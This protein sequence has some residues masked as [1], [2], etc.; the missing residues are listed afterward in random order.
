MTAQT[1]NIHELFL[2]AAVS[3]LP[4]VFVFLFLQRYLVRA[5]RRPASRADR[6]APRQPY[7]TPLFAPIHPGV[8][9]AQ[10]RQPPAAR[11]GHT[12][13]PRL[14]RRRGRTRGCS[15]PS[16]STWA[17]AS[18]PASTSPATPPPTRTAC[19]PTSWTWSANWA[20]PPSATP[21]ATS[22]PATAGRTASARSSE[23]PAPARPAPGAPSRPTSSASTSSCDFCG[24][25]GVEPMMAVNLGTRGVAGGPRPAGV[26]QPPRRH[27]AVRPPRRRTATRSRTASGC[28]AWATRWTA[29]GRSATR[30]PTSTAGSPPR[31]P[32]PCAQVDPGLELVACGSSS[33]SMPTFAAWEATVLEDTYD[34]VDYIS[35][36]RLLRGERRRPST[37][38]SPPPSTWSPS[39]RAS[40]PPAT[41]SGASA[42]VDEADQPL[43][44]RVERL[45]PEPAQPATPTP[46]DWQRGAAPAGGRLHRHRRRRLRP[47]ADRPAAARRPGHRR[48]P[49]PARQRHRADHDRAGRPGLA[50]DHLLPLRPGVARTAAARC[51]GVAVDSPDVRHRPVRRGAAAAR[52]RRP[53]TRTATVTVFAVNRDTTRPLE[54]TADLRAFNPVAGQVTHTALADPDRHAANT[55]Q[56]QDRVTPKPVTGTVTDGGRLSALLPPMSWNT[57]TIPLAP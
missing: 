37:P 12:S 11:R 35:L 24:K 44:R 45:V 40:S 17:A 51:S 8:T 52:H 48:L 19:A 55:L 5:S 10:P 18:T 49:R 57:I 21:A 7:R 46:P 34:L 9:H 14:H 53:A 26:R 22:S 23:R 56:H 25:A 43:L 38:S 33:P 4:L 50:A 29:P 39:S 13:G 31:P 27:R 1:V 30:P 20:S 2:A 36:P 42:Q 3:I 16:S 54:L 15:A 47:P 28:G 41:T 32:A 6:R